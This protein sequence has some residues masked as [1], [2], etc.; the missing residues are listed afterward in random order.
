M[1][2]VS[3]SANTG[4]SQR[5]WPVFVLLLAVVALPTAGVLY[6]MNRAMQSELLV[7]SQRLNEAYDSQL[8][9]AAGKIQLSWQNTLTLL[10]N[11]KKEKSIPEAFA[12]LVKAGQVDSVLFYDMGRFVYP[13]NAAIPRAAMEPETPSWQEAHSLEFAKNSPKEAAEAYSAI[14]RKSAGVQESAMALMA[15]SRCLNKDGRQAEAIGVLTRNFRS[16][17]RFQN[18]VDSQGRWI[19]PNALLFALQLIKDPSNPLFKKTA[20][21]LSELLNDYSNPAMASTQRRFLM[22]QMRSLW[23]DCPRFPTLNAEELAARFEK[24]ALKSGQMQPAGIPNVWAYQIPDESLTALFRQDHLL[25]FMNSSLAGQEPIRGVRLSVRPPGASA[26]SFLSAKIGNDFPSWELGLALEGSDP[27]QSASNQTT[28]TYVWTGILLTAAIIILALL[29]AGYLRR[30]VRLTRLKNDLIA[31]VSHELKTPL[32]SMRLLVDTLRSGHYQDSQLVQEYLQMMAKEN[33]RL[34]RLIEEFLTF[35]RME[36]KKTQFDRSVLQ[37]D[38]IVHAAVDAVGDRLHAPGCRFELEFAP[39]MPAIIGDHDA[40]TTVLIN[41]LDNAL[42][43]TDDAK[44]IR[45]RSFASDGS[46]W[47]EVQDNGIGFPRSAA[48][49]IFG[50][51]YQVDRTLSRR[52]GGCGLGLS[53]VQFIVAAHNGSITARSQPGKG[54]TFTVQLPAAEKTYAK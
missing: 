36:R 44:E 29:M 12:S 19:T 30:Q 53:I 46:V 41:L 48:K 50:R 9:T 40:L 22:E 51:F 26:S 21:L 35:S 23:P 6:Y 1:F 52:A 43:Y 10:T 8:K 28:A 49:K 14:F 42:K 34:S 18:A 45:L 16:G 54:S 32:A 37:A 25:T 20:A 17:A 4:Q 24:T 3:R 33:A 15:Q 39:E 5:L 7:A 2:R 11:A 38:D 27:F 47:F 13:A 31:T